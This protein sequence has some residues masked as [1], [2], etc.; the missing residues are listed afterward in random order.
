MTT[1]KNTIRQKERRAQ[2]HQRNL[3]AFERGE[4]QIKPLDEAAR[5]GLF[6]FLNAAGK[7]ATRKPPGFVI[8]FA[9]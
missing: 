8:G 4:A 6:R 1:N 5:S 9:D 3:E 2:Q 7:H